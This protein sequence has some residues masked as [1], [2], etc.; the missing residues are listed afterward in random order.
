MSGPQFLPIPPSL[1]SLVAETISRRVSHLP[2][3]RNGV[4]VTEKLLMVTLECLNAESTK[5]LPLLTPSNRTPPFSDGLDRFL[6]ARMQ[7]GGRSAAPVIAE[8]LISAGIAEPH[9]ILDRSLHRSRKGIRLLKPWTWD[10]VHE[11]GRQQSMT[12]L[13]GNSDAWMSLCP[14]CKTG[15]LN[16]VT[17]K[18][19]FGIPRTDFIIECTFCG[20]KFIPV[21]TQYRL[22][23]IAT[24]RDPLWK[25]NLNATNSPDSWAALARGVLL[26]APIKKT[27]TP[28]VKI[29]VYSSLTLKERSDGSLEVPCGNK[30]LF[31]RPIRVRTSGAKK[32]DIFARVQKTLDE[33]MALPAYSHL[34]DIVNAKYSRYLSLKAGVFLEQLKSRHDTEYRQF[35]NAYGD[36]RYCTFQLEDPGNYEKKGVILVAVNRCLYQVMDSPES[37]SRSIQRQLGQI[38]PEDCLLYGDSVRC[39]VNAVLCADRE[40]AGLYVYFSE[41]NDDRKRIVD[42]LNRKMQVL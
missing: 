42:E 39:Q 12:D 33:L 37:V 17:G 27:E 14:V 28:A 1:H 4:N 22:V 21:G 35:L 25:K 8:V 31:F 2:F 9:E 40:K 36:E 30:T 13:S 15:I 10:V 5:S 23:S 3:L 11:T 20:A 41:D 19:L 7:V 29:P 16:K 18:Q 38:L 32:S 26:K 6:E 34:K 24:I